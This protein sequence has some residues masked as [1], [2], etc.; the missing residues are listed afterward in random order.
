MESLNLMNRTKL[1]AS[2]TVS[3]KPSM[4]LATRTMISEKRISDPSSSAPKGERYPIPSFFEYR[5]RA[6][7]FDTL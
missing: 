4:P 3:G 6:R 5:I 1:N 2:N 7:D